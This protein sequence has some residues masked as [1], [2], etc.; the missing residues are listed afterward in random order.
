MENFSPEIQQESA[1]L[2]PDELEESREAIQ[3]FLLMMRESGQDDGLH[4]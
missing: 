1:E 2:L 4:S 3:E